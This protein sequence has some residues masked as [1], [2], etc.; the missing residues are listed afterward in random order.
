MDLHLD[1]RVLALA[2]VVTT[3]AGLLCGLLP[4]FGLRGRTSGQ[5]LMGQA[6]RTTTSRGGNRLRAG[7][8][9][10]Q[11]AMSLLLLA[12]TGLMIR[13]LARLLSVDPGFEPRQVL[14]AEVSLPARE[15]PRERVNT[16]FAE[17]A[18]RAAAIPGVEAVG[19]TN[20]L[21]FTPVQRGTSFHDADQPAPA[22]GTS[23]SADIRIADTGFFNAMRIPVLRGRGFDAT[24]LPDGRAVA[25]VSKFLVKQLWGD[26]ADAIGKRV[27][28][29]WGPNGIL[30]EI[31]GVVGDVHLQSL[32]RE[33]RATIWF[34][35]VQQTENGT[36]IALRVKGSPMSYAPQLARELAVMDPNAPLVE[37][38]PMTDWTAEVTASRRYPMLLLAILAGLALVLAAVGLYGV[39]A[40]F[41]G[42]RTRE[43]GVRRALGAPQGSVV[44][45]VLGQGARLVG[46]GLALGGIAAIWGTRFLRGLLFEIGTGDPGAIAGAVLLL[47]LVGLGASL[48]PALRAARVDPAVTLR[49][50]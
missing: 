37:P 35:M 18:T 38:R 13:S 6:G 28:V 7:L 34:P 14:M 46:I 43:I 31:V 15:Y 12:G 29:A 50:E 25:V 19:M 39:L 9:V 24:D 21:P 49:G 22:P 20:G 48:L 40:Y 4:G 32:D 36:H 26:G 23:P 42:E 17:L 27:Q 11:V 5:D 33:P 16:F 8:V 45:L 3:G 30:A 10:L 47:S 41:V 2:L 44:K 1:G